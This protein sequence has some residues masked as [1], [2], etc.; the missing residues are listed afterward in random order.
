M[1]PW[2]KKQQ[3]ELRQMKM[4]SNNRKTVS[5]HTFI[6]IYRG[7]LNEYPLYSP[8]LPQAQKNLLIYY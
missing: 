7:E 2:A 5:I 1:K 4:L 3:L 6:F 8:P